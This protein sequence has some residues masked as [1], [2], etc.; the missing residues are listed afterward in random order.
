[1]AAMATTATAVLITVSFI[2]PTYGWGVITCLE[3]RRRHYLG[4]QATT[5]AKH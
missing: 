1:M 4:P 2:I 3:P 5:A